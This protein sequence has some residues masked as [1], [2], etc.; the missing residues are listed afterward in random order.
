VL[1]AMLGSPA[2]PAW[3]Q[4][5]PTD[6]AS[7]SLEDLMN[8]QVTS[9]SKKEQ[10]LSRTAAAIFV[11]TQE[12]IRRSGAANIPDLL[13]MVPGLDVA[14]ISAN[15]WAVS[16]RG[17]NAQ[18]GNKLLVL[19]DGRSV[20]TPTFSGVFWDT[21]DLP[22]EDIERIEV[23]RGPGGS[24]W[25]AN[26]VNGVINIIT[27]KASE[28]QGSMVVASAGNLDQGSGTAQ[29]GGKLG[30]ATDFRVYGKYF[31]QDHISGANGLSGGD[32]WH[33]LRGGF[34]TDSTL[35]TKDTLTIQGDFYGGREGDPGAV[36]A[37]VTAPGRTF[38][39]LED[40][41]RGGFVQSVWNHTYSTR[42][43]TTLQIS[44]DRYTRADPEL[45]QTRDTVLADFQ[46]NIA[47][48]E[49]QDIVWG[50]GYSFTT[51][52]LGGSL[53][54]SFDPVSRATDLFSSFVQD[55]ISL[56]P[57]RLSLTVGAKLE[58]NA[59]TG[60]AL[61]PSARA[62]WTPFPRNMFWAAVSRAV[63]TPARSDT[64]FRLNI[65]DVAPPAAPPILLSLFGNPLVKN[66][67]LIAYE[68]G[69]RA[70]V[71]GR[72]SLDV[73]AYFND[74]DD[75]QTKEPSAPFFELAPSPPHLVLP[76]V[77][78]NLMHGETH[79]L[80]TS[81]TWKVTDRW[82]F[83]PGYALELIHLHTS[84]Q[85]GDTQSAPFI[86]GTV[87]RHSAELRSHLDLSHRVSGDMSAY[88]VSR[89]TAQSVPSYTRLDAQVTWKIVEGLQLSIVGQ[90]LVRDHRQEFIDP[91]ASENSTGIKR[92]AYAKFTWRF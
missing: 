88:F 26:A 46:H 12:D 45:P 14:Q 55:E 61:M 74:Y 77:Y 22:L 60:I 69:Y 41:V 81:A 58:H 33:L 23:I 20:Y 34:R 44:L 7:Q 2:A 11:I 6:L 50:V 30:N 85:S 80:E 65:G 47:W 92:S 10:P 31:N 56:V 48:G 40:N 84:P 13:R 42:S 39:N 78:G 75:L 72:F 68:M 79:G 38:V 54:I 15:T 25:G 51:D 90:N 21:L 5:K 71:L 37:S 9:V 86:A 35:S 89:L 76:L 36:L 27:K 82:T 62:A 66:E 28:T 63:R 3:P 29:Y 18:F 52:H 32:S 57:N 64:N 59:Y 24:S 17:F 4:Q 43:D 91:Q 8:I 83:S 49:R 53:L 67:G 70:E 73:S 16:A 19:V 1:L 87:P